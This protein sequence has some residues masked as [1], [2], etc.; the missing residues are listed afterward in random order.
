MIER[1][2]RSWV[3]GVLEGMLERFL[4]GDYRA[5]GRCDGIWSG[6]RE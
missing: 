5:S 2:R 1:A 6:L 3:Q 4:P